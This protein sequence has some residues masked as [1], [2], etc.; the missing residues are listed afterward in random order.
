MNWV[1][2]HHFSYTYPGGKSPTLKDVNLSIDR[3]AFVVVT[4]T[5]GSGKSTLG[6]A[7]AGFIFQDEQPDYHGS[8]FV[9]KADM[10]RIPLYQASEHVAYV[11]Q[12]PEDQFCT[13]TV[14]D[15]I[16]FGLENRCVSPDEIDNR[17]EEA[18]Q[19]VQGS[20]LINRNISTL[21]GG[22]KQKVAIAS[23]L[24]LNPDVLILDEPTSNLDPIATQNIFHTLHYIRHKRNLTV[25]I[26]EHKLEQLLDFNPDFYVLDNGNLHNIENISGFQSS[27]KAQYF[28]L[29]HFQE[30]DHINNKCSVEISGINVL[31]NQ[32]PI[33]QDID[34]HLSAGE[35]VALM[36]PNGSGKSTLLQ[37]MMGFH[38]PASGQI[39]LFDHDLIHTKTSTLVQDIGFIF[40]NPDHQLFTQSVWDEVTLTS[41]NL[42]HLS[43]DIKTSAT[44]LLDKIGLGNRLQDHPQSLSY[45]EKRRLNL[46]AVILHMPKLLL[47][48]E[49]LIG[50]DMAHAEAW[51]TFF[52]DFAHQ[53]NIVLL[54]N[55][56]ASL[57]QKYCDRII[58]LDQGRVFVDG[59][60]NMAFERLKSFGFEAFAPTPSG[61][62]SYA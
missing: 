54:V 2:I 58:F 39:H 23:M 36:G 46:L 51:M 60:I 17:I 25:L 27:L 12:N 24:A 4:G 1:D 45:G 61:A 33:L 28:T 5:S 18:L 43:E 57:T 9:N 16:A 56:H 13:L 30:T 49:F 29:P 37:T 32:T 26:I 31:L 3:G 34:I 44:E 8:I 14:S 42:G 15:E 38:K 40:Q 55:H 19:I 6:K 7:L 11:Q 52:R 10:S 53:G 35:F 59:P 20:H 41:K 50:Q 48:D 47:V 62:F 21:S 22:E